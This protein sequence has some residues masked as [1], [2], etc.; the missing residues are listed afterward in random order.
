MIKIIVN[1]AEED[2]DLNMFDCTRPDCLRL[3]KHMDSRIVKC[4]KKLRQKRNNIK[5]KRC[6]KIFSFAKFAFPFI[7]YISIESTPKRTHLNH[8]KIIKPRDNKEKSRNHSFNSKKCGDKNEQREVMLEVIKNAQQPIN[9]CCEVIKNEST[10]EQTKKG[11]SS[12][13]HEKRSSY[14]NLLYHWNKILKLIPTWPSSHY[15]NNSKA[16]SFR[17]HQKSFNYS[18]IV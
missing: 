17:Y 11:A 5:A 10:N 18:E 13:I 3:H 6:H 14:V 16:T 2:Y 4:I 8:K 15:R 7:I 1:L 9:G 12:F